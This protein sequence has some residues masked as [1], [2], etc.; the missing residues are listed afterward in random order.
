MGRDLYVIHRISAVIDVDTCPLLEVCFAAVLLFHDEVAH[1]LVVD[2]IVCMLVLG[3]QLCRPV[4]P[5][6]PGG[7]GGQV[8]RVAACPR[9]RRSRQ[10]RVLGNGPGDPAHAIWQLPRV[11]AGRSLGP[12]DVC[13][14]ED[15][16]VT[17]RR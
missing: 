10:Q 5:R 6:E 11:R 17:E 8:V 3:D 2:L 15:G 12:D 4:Y 13:A 14:A 16:A 7:A 1:N 9:H